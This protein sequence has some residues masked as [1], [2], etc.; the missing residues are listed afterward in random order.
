MAF[1]GTLNI[2]Y[3]RGDTYEFRIYPKDASGAAFDLTGYTAIFKIATSRGSSGVS[4]QIEATAIVDSTT[5]SYLTCTITPPQGIQ[6]SAGTTYV[7]DVQIKKAS[8]LIVYT[9]LTGTISVTD[10]VS[11]TG[12]GTGA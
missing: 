9:L 12:S 3:Y 10:D 1:P 8:P 2:S 5:N 11:A 7:Y 6:L 4:G